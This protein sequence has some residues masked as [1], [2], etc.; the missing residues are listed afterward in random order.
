MALILTVV[1]PLYSDSMKLS[2]F[3][4]SNRGKDILSKFI[5]EVCFPLIGRKHSWNMGNLN[6]YPMSWLRLSPKGR[7]MMY[8]NVLLDIAEAKTKKRKKMSWP[9]LPRVDMTV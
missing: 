7:A 3:E 8:L 5:S 4:S 6:I 1:N 2:Y 9:L